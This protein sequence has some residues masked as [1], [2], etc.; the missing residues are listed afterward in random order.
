MGLLCKEL[1]FDIVEFNAS[2]TRNKTLIKEQIGELLT[3]TSLSAYA[4]G[5]PMIFELLF[6][7][8]LLFIYYIL[9]KIITLIS[10]NKTL[11][12]NFMH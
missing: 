3:T 6:L 11:P 1:G 8:L 2:D 7:Y 10:K 12:F 9:T 4:K 5:N